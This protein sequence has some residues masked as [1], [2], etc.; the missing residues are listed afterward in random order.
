MYTRT[1]TNRAEYFS[2]ARTQTQTH[3]LAHNTRRILYVYKTAICGRRTSVVPP[4]RK[5]RFLPPH[6]TLTARVRVFLCVSVC[7]RSS[8]N[9]NKAPLTYCQLSEVNLSQI[10]FRRKRFRPSWPEN[11]LVSNYLRIDRTARQWREECCLYLH[12]PLSLSHTPF[13]SLFLTLSISYTLNILSL[14]LIFSRSTSTLS[15]LHLSHL[16]YM[17]TRTHTYPY[18]PPSN[19]VHGVTT[20]TT[21]KW[22]VL[23]YIYI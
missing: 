20:I 23:E 10:N 11:P 9:T 7:V 21:H 18:I 5:G 19:H 22:Y 12:L 4:A 15:L 17:Y 13:H 6:K 3:S 8:L 16:S 1:H 14:Y 2:F